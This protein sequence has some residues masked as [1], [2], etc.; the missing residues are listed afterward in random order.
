MKQVILILLICSFPLAAQQTSRS[1][2][3]LVILHPGSEWLHKFNFLMK[4]PP[5]IALWLEDEEGGFLQTIYVTEKMGT[6]GWKMSKGSRRAEA[7]P[8]WSHKSGME[9]SGNLTVPD[10]VTAA[11]PRGESSLSFTPPP[12]GKP[13]RVLLEINQSTDFNES[14]ADDGHWTGPSLASGQPSLIYRGE[15]GAT[16]GKTVIMKLEGH[17]SPDGSDGG[18][19]EDCSGFTTALDILAKAEVVL[20]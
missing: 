2:E 7:L 14:W 12:G 20:P 6:Q 3:A 10:A 17:G 1:D 9:D 4:Q 8:Y 16:R 19:Y 13:F 11:T 18:L 15:V 5:Q